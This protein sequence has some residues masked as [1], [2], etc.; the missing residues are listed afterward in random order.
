M[1]DTNRK[2]KNKISFSHTDAQLAKRVRSVY[3]RDD[4]GVLPCHVSSYDDVISHYST[5]GCETLNPEFNAYIEDAVAFIPSEYPVTLEISGCAFSETEQE[6]I[7]ETIKEDFMYDLGTVQEQNASQRK[8]S[9]F[10]LIGMVLTGLF[11][12]YWEGLSE[13]SLEFIY[14]VFWFFAD[15]IINFVVFD[16]PESWERRVRAGRL[17]EMKVIFLEAEEEGKDGNKGEEN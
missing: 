11:V 5:S 15:L 2:I 9:L 10:M 6:I 8:V 14:I 12:T 3:I 7:R 17:A 1:L 13:I 16:N 4:E